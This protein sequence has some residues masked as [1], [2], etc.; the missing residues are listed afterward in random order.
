MRKL[1]FQ[2]NISLDGFADHTIGIADDELHNFFTSQLDNIDIALL[3]RITYQLMESYWPNVYHDPNASKSIIEFANKFNS[4]PKIVFSRTLENAEWNN[5]KLIKENVVEEVIKLKYQPGKNLLVGGISLCQ[6][7]IRLGLIDE[8]WL[9]VH[10]VIAGKGRRLFDN[11][12]KQ[13]NLKLIDTINLKSGI[14]VLHY[15]L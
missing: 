9:L 3:G 11:I 5:T 6:E 13:I 1:I 7:F 10:P 8:F 2:I 12:E 4:M 14:V 15:S